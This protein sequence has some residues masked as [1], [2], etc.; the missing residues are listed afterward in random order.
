MV[1]NSE[2]SLRIKL[3]FHEWDCCRLSEAQLIHG[4]SDLG[5]SPTRALMNALEHHKLTRNLSYID[6][7]KALMHED[8]PSSFESSRSYGDSKA[9]PRLLNAVIFKDIPVISSAK[10]P[11]GTDNNLYTRDRTTESAIDSLSAAVIDST[12]ETPR[13]AFGVVPG[14]KDAFKESEEDSGPAFKYRNGSHLSS[15]VNPVTG[16]GLTSVSRIQEHAPDQ[17]YVNIIT[18]EGL[19]DEHQN[20]MG[21]SS[22]KHFDDKSTYK[23]SEWSSDTQSSDR[24]RNSKTDRTSDVITHNSDRPPLPYRPIMKVG[25]ARKPEFCPFATDADDLDDM[26]R[27]ILMNPLGRISAPEPLSGSVTLQ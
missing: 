6:F 1:W 25:S 9:V 16:Q 14:A 7:V 24:R 17:R 12:A 15:T 21:V 22:R 2:T 27:R 26:R 8:A 13:R 18:G 23:M 3:L 10:A 20:T 4:I 5:I 11:Y 19:D